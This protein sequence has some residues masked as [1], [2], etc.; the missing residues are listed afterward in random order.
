M[1]DRKKT[2]DILG[3]LLGEI[4]ESPK[5]M[6]NQNTIEPEYHKDGRP[7][8]HKDGKSEEKHTIKPARQKKSISTPEPQVKEEETPGDKVKA[9]YYIS[10][11]IVE[12]LEEGW[13]QLRRLT[14]K[15]QR[16]QISKSLIVELALQVALEELES[17]GSESNLFK[18]SMKE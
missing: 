15:D 3:S 9:T 16:A 4:K 8:Y 1:T 12:S 2:P 11:E 7:E 13:I 10:S 18:R 5:K 14:P 17:K 6:V